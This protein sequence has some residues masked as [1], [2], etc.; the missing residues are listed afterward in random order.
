MQGASGC[1]IETDMLDID[2]NP[3]QIVGVLNAY[4]AKMAESVGFKALYLSGAAVANMAHGLPDTGLT[5]L[6]DVA[7]EA[8]KITA[9]TSLPL[10]V[11][12]DTGWGREGVEV[13]EKCGVA[14][15]HIEDQIPH[16]RCGHLEG[17]K[18]VPLEEMCDRL[19]MALEARKNLLVMARSDAYGVEGMDGLLKR[20]EAYK[21]LG[22]NMIFP[23]ALPSIEAYKQVCQT[24]ELP[25]LANL[26]EFG[27]TP[28]LSIEELKSAGVRMALY[29]LSITRAMNL[30]ALESL[31][32]LRSEK[33]QQGF[34]DRMQTREELYQF[35]DYQ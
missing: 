28:L 8:K 34:V 30:A 21:K 3:L 23:E 35:L 1:D 4:V 24:I 19:Q 32:T 11:D 15:V 31:K 6:E 5:T 13:M 33:T 7:S 22:C 25:V 29:P 12:I 18:L 16:K 2:E 10:L 14:A 9:A 17:K 27:K 20:L 26:T